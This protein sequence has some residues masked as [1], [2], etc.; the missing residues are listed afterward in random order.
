MTTQ[1]GRILVLALGGTIACRPTGAGLVPG[2]TAAD[3]LAA[4]DV[5]PGLTVDGV[6]PMTRTILYPADWVALCELVAHHRSKYDGF[7]ITLGTDTLAHAAAALSLMLH[8]LDRTVVLTG[9][10]QAIGGKEG[11]PARRNLGDA[12]RV[13]A[14]GHAGVF[15]VF[16]G[17]IIDGCCASKQRSDSDDAFESINA[18]PWGKV[19][20]GKLRWRRRP[21]SPAGRFRLRTAAN[22]NVALL[23]LAPQTTPAAVEALGGYDGVVVAGYGDGNVS[24]NLVAALGALAARRLVV[25]TSQCPHGAV[26]H[27]Y[28]GGAA[29][30]R[31]GA[32]SAGTLSVEMATVKLMWALGQGRTIA[33]ARR[34]FRTA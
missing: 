32:L 8:G 9:A 10:M 24:D 1:S 34:L 16:Q 14:A 4:I 26:R 19:S 5:P 2:L 20:G 15:V 7:V 13:A 3:L 31:A 17:K 18:A 21:P 12:L 25:L 30:I 22:L 11:R 28:A 27:R 6:D 23:Q 33:G 29:L